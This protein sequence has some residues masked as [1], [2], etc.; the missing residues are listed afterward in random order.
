MNHEYEGESEPEPEDE[1][2][3]FDVFRDYARTTGR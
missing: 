3:V 2:D 1:I